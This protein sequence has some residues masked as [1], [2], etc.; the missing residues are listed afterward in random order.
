MGYR[1]SDLDPH[2]RHLP[3]VQLGAVSQ[4]SAAF[5][6]LRS[7]LANWHAWL[8]LAWLDIKHKYRRS[9]LGP[10]WIT[11]T[12]GVLIGGIGLVYSTLFRLDIK[13]YLPYIAL[14]D[15]TWIY[16]ST[17]MQDAATT[18]SGSAGL[19]RSARIPLTLHVMR[20]ATRNR[21]IYMHGAVVLVPVLIYGELAPSPLWAIS[22]LG[23]LAI[24][25]ISIPLSIVI[26]SLAARFSDLGPIISN[27]M[28]LL[29]FMTPIIWHAEM[30]GNK[31]FIAD[32]NPF[33]HFIELVR[34]PILGHAPAALSFWMVG[35]CLVVSCVAAAVVLVVLRKRISVWV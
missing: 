25:L 3:F 5:T 20:V 23:L 24:A 29:F 17:I 13:A 33:Y 6:D 2:Y 8:L 34:A 4:L 14:G 11:I 16:M 21:L 22:L 31:R 26:G 12:M 27:G 19:I 9:V 35:S 1:L 18:F 32:W 30:L 7:G 15:T 28:Q 10:F